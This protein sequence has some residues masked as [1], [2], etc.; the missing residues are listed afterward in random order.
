MNLDAV[1]LDPFPKRVD[2]TLDEEV[3]FDALQGPASWREP[4]VLLKQVEAFFKG[5]LAVSD[6]L[7]ERA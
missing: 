6:D 2:I 4:A 3:P 5:P 1:L 7:I